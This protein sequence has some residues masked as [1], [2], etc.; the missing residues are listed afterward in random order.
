ME[1]CESLFI[2]VDKFKGKTINS[3][4]EKQSTDLVMAEAGLEGGGSSQVESPGPGQQE[5][6]TRAAREQ[7]CGVPLAERGP[8]AC[9]I[10]AEVLARVP[11]VRGRQKQSWAEG[12]VELT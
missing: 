1:L 4:E 3:I 8:K 6:R 5:N 2:F 9:W 10:S 12:R 11:L 7:P